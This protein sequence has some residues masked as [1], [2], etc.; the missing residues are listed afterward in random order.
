[1]KPPGNPPGDDVWPPA[2]LR[3]RLAALKGLA[4][5][6]RCHVILAVRA[7]AVPKRRRSAA[8]SCR[9]IRTGSSEPEFERW[10]LEQGLAGSERLSVSVLI[11]REQLDEADMMRECVMERRRGAVEGPYH[12][13][14][15][16]VECTGAARVV[17]RYRALRDGR[18]AELPDSG[19]PPPTP[20]PDELDTD[21]FAGEDDALHAYLGA[22]AKILQRRSP[23]ALE[24]RLGLSVIVQARRGD[25]VEVAC[26]VGWHGGT[27]FVIA[28]DFPRHRVTLVPS[29][30]LETVVAETIR[31]RDLIRYETRRDELGFLRH[32]PRARRR[33][34]SG[35]PSAWTGNAVRI[36]PYVPGRSALANADQRRWMTYAE[37]YETRTILD[38]LDDR[39]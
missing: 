34:L 11:I 33:V 7:R 3:A 35:E 20:Q 32:C 6:P 30:D 5:A 18:L 36:E 31:S 19:P 25:G 14:V 29:P 37:T 12:G 27:P 1:M 22:D 13:N 16:R 9:A 38:L 28:A 17:R 2:R 21:G 8:T 24:D 39:R 15:A 26:G 10:L 4:P 23:S